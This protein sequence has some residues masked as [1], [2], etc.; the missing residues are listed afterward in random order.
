MKHLAI[1]LLA[2][3]A[4]FA[5]PGLADATPVTSSSNF[6]IGWSLPYNGTTTAAAT[7][8][9]SNF[10]FSVAHQVTFTMDVTNTSTG[11]STNDVRF[12]SFGWDTSPA[13]SAVTD[14]TSVYASVIGQSIGPDAVSVCFYAGSNCNGGGNGGLEDSNHTGV[15]GDPTTTGAFSVT[16][17]FGN[18]I[19]PPLDF[20][21]FDAKFQGGGSLGSIEGLGTCTSGCTVTPAPEPATT[22]LFG[23]GLVALGIVR[24][25]RQR[26]ARLVRV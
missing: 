11:T 26:A 25:R 22:A 5:A 12:T 21:N 6:T 13:T 7:A 20:S 2:G 8:S 18:S 15:H 10:D 4:A 1:L 9:F 24:R 3:V 16:V 14:S 17:T 23:T 19:V